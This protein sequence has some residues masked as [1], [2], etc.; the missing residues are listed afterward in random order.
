MKLKSYMGKIFQIG[1]LLLVLSPQ[2][3]SGATTQFEFSLEPLSSAEIRLSPP[4][5]VQQDSVSLI[6]DL[7]VPVESITS[8]TISTS[9]TAQHAGYWCYGERFSGDPVEIV[10]FYVDMA[11]FISLESDGVS[12]GEN[13]FLLNG[14]F[15][16][17]RELGSESGI[18]DGL[19][20][21]GSGVLLIRYGQNYLDQDNWCRSNEYRFT[22]NGTLEFYSMILTITYDQLVGNRPASWGQVKALFR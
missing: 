18:P 20:S 15:E 12:I 7:G 22:Q 19:M 1:A 6:V 11:I 3:A 13:I 2:I 8:I 5:A 16:T 10:R 9:G 21:N 4:N 14:P 17:I